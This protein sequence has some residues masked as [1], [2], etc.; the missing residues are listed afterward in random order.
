MLSQ[1]ISRDLLCVLPV[2]RGLA[3]CIARAG[4]VADAAVCRST[5]DAAACADLALLCDW[6][7]TPTVLLEMLGGAATSEVREARYLEDTPA[8]SLVVSADSPGAEASYYASLQTC[9]ALHNQMRLILT[10]CWAITGCG[11]CCGLFAVLR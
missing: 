6:L 3:G 8:T 11:W 10:V 7:E 9:M 1:S 4:H 2:A 5:A